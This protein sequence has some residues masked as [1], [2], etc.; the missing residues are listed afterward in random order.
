MGSAWDND[1]PERFGPMTVKE[2]RQNLRRGSFVYPFIGIQ[3]LAVLAVVAEFQM[4]RVGEYTEYIGMLNLGMLFTSGPFWIVVAVI[5]MVIMPLGG[6]ILM[7][8]E[9]EEGNHELLLLTQLNRW[10]VVLGKFYTIWGLCALTFVSLLPYVVVRYLLG[11]IEWWR[12]SCCSLSVLGGSAIIAAGAIGASSFKGLAARIGIMTLFLFSCVGACGVPLASSA[13]MGT[14]KG[15]GV[16]YHLNAISS[17]FCYTLLGLA[18][19]RS[20]LRLVVHAYEVKPSWM[21]V[22]LLVFTPFVV[23]MTTLFTGG[24]AGLV[25]LVGMA[26]VSIYSDVTPKAPKWMAAPPPNVPPPPPMPTA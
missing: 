9:L 20:R 19:A 23:W 25:G 1:L 7:G 8:Q 3:L 16:W 26:F 2:L 12:E 21:I 6:L 10:K 13:N 14:V 17:V 18:L 11:S 4:R 22:G 24:Y 5:C 15:C